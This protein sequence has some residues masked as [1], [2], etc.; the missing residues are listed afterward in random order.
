M[1]SWSA[2]LLNSLLRHG[3]R[4]K[5][6]NQRA[7]RER[8]R[9][10]PLG[11]ERSGLATDE[12]LAVRADGAAR[13]GPHP[14]ASRCRLR[15]SRRSATR[16][17]RGRCGRHLGRGD[18]PR[19]RVRREPLARRV[20]R[21]DDRPAWTRRPARRERRDPDD[22]GGRRPPHLEPR[23]QPPTACTWRRSGRPRSSTASCVRRCRRSPGRSSSSTPL[24]PE[25]SRGL[26]DL[27]VAEPAG[28]TAVTALRATTLRASRRPP[29]PARRRPRRSR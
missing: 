21:S 17:G 11:G 4:V 13:E 16:G 6:A 23:D 1:P 2:P 10:D 27:E 28:R 9:P 25:T 3:D 20:Q 8:D 19:G 18:R 15:R 26:G 12:L 24:G 29:G 7:A 14:C 5:I 22:P